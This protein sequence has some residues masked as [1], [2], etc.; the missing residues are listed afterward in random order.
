L[1]ILYFFIT[2]PKIAVSARRSVI[3]HQTSA[4]VNF[5]AEISIY[6]SAIFVGGGAKFGFVPLRKVPSLR[7]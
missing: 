1:E 5:C 7:Y 3:I 4:L 2:I 6:Y